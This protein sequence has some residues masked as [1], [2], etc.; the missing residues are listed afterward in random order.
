VTNTLSCEGLVEQAVGWVAR[1]AKQAV[2][3]PAE[4][5]GGFSVRREGPITRIH[6]D[7]HAISLHAMIT[8]SSTSNFTAVC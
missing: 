5:S 8:P 4:A 1:Q 6:R 2:E 3:I 7:V